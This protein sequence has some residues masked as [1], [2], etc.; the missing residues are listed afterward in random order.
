MLK[1]ELCGFREDIYVFQGSHLNIV[2]YL[3]ESLRIKNVD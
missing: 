1:G 3:S 2:T